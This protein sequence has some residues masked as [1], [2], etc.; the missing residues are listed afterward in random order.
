[1]NN[2]DDTLTVWQSGSIITGY[3]IGGGVMAL[4]YV[5]AKVGVLGAFGVLTLAFIS[6]VILHIMIAELSLKSGEDGQIIA[7]FS[8][9]LFKGKA[10]TFLT[11]AF[12]VIMALVLVF[13][14][15]AYVE[16][17]AELISPL[18]GLS[19]F[20][21]KL[22]FYVL[23]ASVVLFGLKAVGISESI[24]VII[25][26]ILISILAIFS[27]MNIKNDL[28]LSFGGV[29]PM[30]AFFGLSMFSFSAFFS[31]PQA[32]KGLKGDRKKI[33]KAICIGM[34]N[35][36]I[37]IILVTLSALL[38]SVEIT[39]VAM[40]GWSKGIGRWAEL[41]G[42]IFTLLA[43]LTTYWS[44]SLA[45]SDIIHEQLKLDS[46]LCWLCATLPSL[47]V[48][49]LNIASFMDFMRIAGGLIAIIVALMVVPAYRCCRKEGDENLLG[50]ASGTGMDVFIIAM[51]VLMAVGN[52][53]AI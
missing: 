22:I 46:R 8:R 13:N 21:S 40:V 38:S 33:R 49:F 30:L 27:F 43:M 29:N 36:Y 15:A 25:I 3:G 42:T 44:I 37:L 12:F 2:K 17:A 4:P 53:V 45:L 18:L 23:A 11:Y 52:V 39:Q 20:V 16:G 48:T 41:V 47:A 34:L 14:L 26:Y 9:Y 19:S 5:A 28:P 1:M 24:S 31:V 6:S 7:A 50:K 32:V 51:Y 10:K 35:N